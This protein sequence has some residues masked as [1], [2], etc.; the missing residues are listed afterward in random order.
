MMSDTEVREAILRERR[1]NEWIQERIA[2][3]RKN[4]GDS[5]IAVKDRKIV[6]SDKDFD[7]LLARIKKLPDQESV[8]IEYISLTEYLWML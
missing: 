3:L 6:D 4:Y 1:N 5:Y 2:M 8:T 7:A